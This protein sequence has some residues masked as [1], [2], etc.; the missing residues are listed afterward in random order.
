MR[1]NLIQQVSIIHIIYL[2][3]RALLL[4]H[5]YI[6]QLLEVEQSLYTCL[7]LLLVDNSLWGIVV[8]DYILEWA[9]VSQQS[10]LDDVVAE[11][12]PLHGVVAVD[13]NLFEEVD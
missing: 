4:D 10:K 9:I 13:V 7:M 1:I 6:F 12:L 3:H 2:E 11:L 8:L 5:E